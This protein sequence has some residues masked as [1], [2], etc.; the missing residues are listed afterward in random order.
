MWRT[1]WGRDDEANSGTGEGLALMRT[2][3][4]TITLV[5]VTTIA[6]L[7]ALALGLAVNLIA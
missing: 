3:Y 2:T 7:C 1:G 5:Q 6:G 4:S